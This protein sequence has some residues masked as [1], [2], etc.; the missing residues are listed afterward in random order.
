MRLHSKKHAPVSRLLTLDEVLKVVHL[1]LDEAAKKC[2][3]RATA[4]KKQCRKLG[5]DKWPSRQVNSVQLTESRCR[6][7]QCQDPQASRFAFGMDGMLLVTSADLLLS[8][9][10]ICLA[11][12]LMHWVRVSNGSRGRALEALTFCLGL[13]HQSLAGAFACLMPG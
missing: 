12:W 1:R 10:Q 13:Q 4:F 5:I 2:G 9:V 6:G 11:V 3:L 7:V 8:T